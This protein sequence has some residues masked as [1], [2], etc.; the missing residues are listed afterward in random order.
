MNLV[1][2]AV[3]GGGR[4]TCEASIHLKDV[5]DRD[6]TIAALEQLQEQ[7]QQQQQDHKHMDVDLTSKLVRGLAEL[8]EE[9]VSFNAFWQ[10]WYGHGR[11]VGIV[12]EPKRLPYYKSLR[13]MYLPATVLPG[14]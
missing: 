9:E 2:D 3:P 8:G 5:F 10:G 1:E 6:R 7:Q 4:E 11:S 13:Y 14:P 12:L